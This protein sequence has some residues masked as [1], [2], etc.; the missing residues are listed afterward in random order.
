[1]KRLREF[2]SLRTETLQ[3]C[4]TGD[5]RS[6][7]I[8]T[9]LRDAA[10]G[11]SDVARAGE[12]RGIFS[13]PPYVGLIDYHEQ[14]AYAY[15]LLGFERRDRMEIGKLSDGQSKAA[16]EAYAAGVSDVL[17]NC[18]SVLADDCDIFLVANDKH[19]LFSTIAERASLDIIDAFRRPVLNRTEKDRSSYS[20]TIFHMK[21]AR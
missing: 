14:H 11:L 7:D 6:L 10:P 12:V 1:M 9:A 4:L 20:E 16:K 17:I 19:D 15:E 21:I 5:A 13:S 2:D 3:H 18:Q 8:G